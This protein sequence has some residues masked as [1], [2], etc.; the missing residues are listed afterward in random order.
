MLEARG[1]RPNFLVMV[2]ASAPRVLSGVICALAGV[3][4][5]IKSVGM[6]NL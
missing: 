3:L 2:E 5:N 6:K 1:F 4:A